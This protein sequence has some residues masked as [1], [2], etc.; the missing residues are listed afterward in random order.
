MPD[1]DDERIK[2][3]MVAAADLE[4]AEFE[5]DRLALVCREAVERALEAGVSREDAAA[6]A[7][8]AERDV[9]RLVGA[10]QADVVV[11][12]LTAAPVLPA[13][14]VMAPV[15]PAVAPMPVDEGGMAAAE[16]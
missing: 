16:A 5:R 11:P 10:P 2:R 12:L 8:I 13:V 6:A 7:G 14:A 15:P 1:L 3:I 4:N 9:E